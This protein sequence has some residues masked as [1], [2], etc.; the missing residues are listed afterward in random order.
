[1]T[2]ASASTRRLGALAVVLVAAGC[3][4]G[5]DRSAPRA[6]LWESGFD[7]VRIEAQDGTERGVPPNEHPARFTAEQIRDLL[8]ALRIRPMPQSRSLL[9]LV[10]RDGAGTVPA[11][12]AVF[13]TVDLDKIA[14]P[15][16]EAL[17]RAGPRKD[18]AVAVSSLREG[19]I[20]DFLDTNRTTSARI[21]FLDGRLNVIFGV[22]HAA[23]RDEVKKK[24]TGT[25]KGEYVS[26][27]D[28]RRYQPRPGSRVSPAPVSLV[29]EP[30]P[31]LFY[32]SAGGRKRGD[33]IRIDAA[34]VLAALARE[35]EA[36]AAPAAAGLD[37]TTERIAREHTA[38]ERKVEEL[39]REIRTGRAEPPPA[40]GTAVVAPAIP[41]AEVEERLVRLRD[42]YD[43][44]VI[45]SDL[46]LAKTAE[47][48]L[49]L[50]AL[51]TENWLERLTALY[52]RG[53]IAKSVYFE[54]A[55][56]A[57]DGE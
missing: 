44:E 43:R 4:S 56:R 19:P 5:I 48:L 11:Y 14:A 9:R 41:V 53:L 26:R 33:W 49:G 10:G 46:Y 35:R 24:P 50:R 8:G 16:A 6:V 51:P 34:V 54:E 37:A 39:E 27:I 17:A 12:E 36:H 32:A 31:A 29:L 21:F 30:H 28:E 3:G 40:A 20:V 42:L 52:E 2:V 1:M 45:A 23:L 13:N 55:G 7:Y 38:L 18:V 57:L 22:V 25:P 47:V 15:V